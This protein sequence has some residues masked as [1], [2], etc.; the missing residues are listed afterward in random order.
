MVLRTKPEERRGAYLA[1]R[2]RLCSIPIERQRRAARPV[3]AGVLLAFILL[4]AGL[5]VGIGSRNGWC[6]APAAA[7][8][9]SQPAPVEGNAQS[10]TSAEPSGNPVQTPNSVLQWEG[11]PVRSIAFE[12]VPADQVQPL[13]A[14]LPQAEGAPLTE[15]NL[16][17]SL[18]QL[19]AT[20]LYDTIEARGT[21][22]TDGVALVFVGT[23]R[24]FI[25]SV[26]VDGATGATMNMQLQR[27]SQL[28]TGTRLT[29]EK[30]LRAAQQMHSTLEQNGFFE[31]AITQ[32]ITA[33]PRQQLAD[34]SF[35]VVSGPRARVGKV[36]VTGDSG[37]TVDEFRQHAHLS[38]IAH[39]DHDTV[40]RALDGV[41]RNYQKQDRLEAEVKLESAA[42]DHATKAVNYQ[43]SANRGPVVHVEV[44]GA[45]IDAERIKHII[46]IYQEGSVD[47]DLLNEGNR[48]LRDY[49]QR[50]GY[51]DAQVDHQQQTAA[52]EEV[53]ILY[54]VQLGSRRRVEQVSV[55]GNHYRAFRSM[56]RVV[57]HT[58]RHCYR[59]SMERKQYK[60]HY[61]HSRVSYRDCTGI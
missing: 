2:C 46:P 33:R 13:A 24:T 56:H 58:G 30:M 16:K 22:M 28:D 1:P 27:A 36:T 35:R 5:V 48:R 29:Q 3:R 8:T 25:G 40:N 50:L 54:T 14:H 39:V 57:D 60:C 10:A 20:G 18:R 41:L 26:S 61:Y 47:E 15:E 7:Q 9:T 12:G 45:S 31:A 38:K 17:S 4:A 19:Y 59:R 44:H 32:N 42:Y 55:T 52:A 21:R 23:P 43:F 53:T 37:M 6:Q 11:L 51:F 34:I 49:Y